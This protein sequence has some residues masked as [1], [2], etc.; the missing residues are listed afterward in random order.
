MKAFLKKVV[1]FGIDKGVTWEGGG[2]WVGYYP[3][4]QRYIIKLSY[5][6]AY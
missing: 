3:S 5:S 1:N 4:P 6:L 2:H